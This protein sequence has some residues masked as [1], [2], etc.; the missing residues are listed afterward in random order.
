M[1]TLSTVLLSYNRLHLLKKT[2]ESYLS[3]ISVPHELIIVDNA[4]T[5]DC[6]R[7]IEN[8]CKK[9][10][11]ITGIFL[12][13]NFG[14]EAFNIG[15]S[16]ASSPYLH[17]SE[18]DLEYLPNWDKKL[19]KKFELFPKLGQLS[20][21]SHKPQSELGEIWEEHKFKKIIEKDESKIFLTDIDFSYV[22]QEVTPNR[23]EDL[24]IRLENDK[25]KIES[26]VM[27]QI[28]KKNNLDLELFSAA[29]KELER[30]IKETNNFEKKLTDFQN[31]CKNKN[32]LSI[33]PL[34]VT[35]RVMYS[36]KKKELYINDDQGTKIIL[37]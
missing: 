15:L 25:S 22:K 33:Q 11:S 36:Q 13:K 19:L 23:N 27:D 4:S 14:G 3:T 8:I 9:E 35:D 10:S 31:R 2:V 37:N 26:D 17:T 29:N 16:L 30:R 18:N 28:T 24:I 6:R 1:P 32:L 5:E 21:Y 20:L 12:T 7:Y 34:A